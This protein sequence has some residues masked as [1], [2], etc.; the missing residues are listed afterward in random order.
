MFLQNPFPHA[1]GLE[2]GD[3]SLKLVQLQPIAFHRKN[4]FDVKEIREVKLP[5]GLIV[6]GEI[7]QPELVRKKLLHIL[8][9]DGKKYPP[10]KSPWVVASLPEVKTFIKLIKIEINPDDINEADVLFQAKKHLPFEDEEKTHISWQIIN[11]EQ[12]K[13]YAQ[14]LVGAVPKLIGDSYTYLL[15]S[16]QLTPLALE[17]E[18]LSITRSLITHD[19]SYEGEGRIILDLGA[20]RSSLIIYD[21]N[22]V[23]F[24][25]S[26]SFSG[27]L[28]TTAIKQ[29]MKIDHQQ[30]EELK[31]KNGV[32][33][34]KKNTKYLKIV[35]EINDKLISELDS[36]LEFYNDHFKNN[37]PINHITM[38]GGM[39]K[40]DGLD[41][42]ISS[43]LKVSS[44]PGNVWKNLQ[45]ENMQRDKRMA[46]L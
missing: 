18:A 27:E 15:E 35:S 42:F 19:K 11:R 31:I 33:F 23:Q 34:D 6:N 37:N 7:Q 16:V 14:I 10:I 25:I 44:H 28:V 32:K 45:N 46:L 3:L 20:T 43:K 30:A 4:H 13:E 39:S 12:S 36:A 41:N 8:G 1:F 9:R 2:I 21:N 38:C 22:T 29:A 40:W 5:A 17:I 26:L 24:S